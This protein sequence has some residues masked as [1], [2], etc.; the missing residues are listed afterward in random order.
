MTIADRTVR[1]RKLGLLDP[2]VEKLKKCVPMLAIKPLRETWKKFPEK[3]SNIEGSFLGGWCDPFFAPKAAT[4]KSSRPPIT[5][6][7]LYNEMLLQTQP[8]NGSNFL[9]GLRGATQLERFLEQTNDLVGQVWIICYVCWSLCQFLQ[10]LKKDEWVWAKRIFH[11]KAAAVGKK[12][13]V[14]MFLC[15]FKVFRAAR[16]D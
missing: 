10:Q 11:E 2:E 1:L 15:A 14:F 7:N 5:G 16:W 3:F 4:P 13:S 6:P 8:R 9:T 12:K